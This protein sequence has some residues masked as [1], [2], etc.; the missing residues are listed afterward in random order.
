MGADLL[1]SWLWT[2][3]P[4]KVD[5]EKARALIRAEITSDC[6]DENEVW[7]PGVLERWDPNED[8]VFDGSDVDAETLVK[9][10]IADVD[11]VEK[12]WTGELEYRDA[13]VTDIGPVR[14]LLSGGMSWGDSPSETFDVLN[15]FG[16]TPA[17]K[18][19]GFF[20]EEAT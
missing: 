12:L 16:N 15:R 11:E 8:A 7:K 1:L 19:A 14:V 10:L 5:F 4:E 20:D 9:V 13:F 3:E 17:A 2:T 18:A 6:L